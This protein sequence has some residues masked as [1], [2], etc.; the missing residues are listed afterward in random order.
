M[1]ASNTQHTRTLILAM[2][3]SSISLASVIVYA[4]FIEYSSEAH[5]TATYFAVLVSGLVLTVAIIVFRNW[6][7]VR[8]SEA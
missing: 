7:A 8:Y 4:L 2:I 5:P 6:K 3:V 1:A